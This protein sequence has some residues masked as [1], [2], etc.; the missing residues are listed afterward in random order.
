MLDA[1]N[2]DTFPA[3]R[4][5]CE[6]KKES[7]LPMVFWIGAGASAWAGLSLWKELAEKCLQEFARKEAAFDKVSASALIEKGDFAGLFSLCKR[8]NAGRYHTFLRAEL[9]SPN[10]IPPVY[11][12]FIAALQKIEPLMVIT[13]NADELLEHSLRL[14]VLVGVNLEL[15]PR[16]IAEKERFVAKLHGSIS[17][18]ASLVFTTEDYDRVRISPSHKAMLTAVL[19]ASTVVFIGY[20]ASDEY[21]FRI[22][23]DNA[24]VNSVFGA[25]PHF[26]CTTEE[27]CSLPTSVKRIKYVPIPFRDHRTPIQVIEELS[28]SQLINITEEAAAL[29]LSNVFPIAGLKSAHML[30]DCLPPGEWRSA[31]QVHVASKDESEKF[32][33][34]VGHGLTQQEM[35]SPVSTALHDFVVGLLCFDQIYIPLSVLGK[36]NLL[37][38]AKFFNDLLDADLLRFVRFFSQEGVVYGGSYPKGNVVSMSYPPSHDGEVVTNLEYIQREL[39]AVP[40]R[41]TEAAAV[42]QKIES[43]IVEVSDDIPIPILVRS[44]LLRPSIRKM[45][46]MSQGTETSTVPDWLKFPILRLTGVVRLGRACQ[47]LNLSSIK[48]GLGSDQ[49]AGP[50][51]AA[52]SGRAYAET[53]ASYV[54]AGN[55]NT[56]LGA[57]VGAN[58]SALPAILRFRETSRGQAL[59]AEI[60][61]RLSASG[62]GDVVSSINAGLKEAL[63]HVS[64]EKYRSEFSS[65]YLSEVGPRYP[66][67]W[68]DDSQN[69]DA[70]QR[71]RA[72]AGE[73]FRKFCGERNLRAYDF[74]PCGSG[75]KIRFCCMEALLVNF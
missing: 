49:I 5:L 34:F 33:L 27:K 62:G 56:D 23:C 24:E 72:K 58:P 12:R 67:V 60:L 40:G 18:V 7:K 8:A 48:F 74:C 69:R 22:L 31:Q 3:L 9:K 28:P 15:A 42:F 6:I 61:A 53:I 52:A 11:A 19:A 38:G 26:I 46:G 30:A 32:T 36:I 75:E 59:R 50:V 39:S 51:F 54:I 63:P 4:E 41:E 47:K 10:G 20:G 68:I 45:I 64:L 17:D 43:K 2:I 73:S 14:P 37:V 55:F 1:S 44:L 16:L 25:G 13:T 35:A 65:L 66:A 29:P 71:W 21:I 70:L 57:Y